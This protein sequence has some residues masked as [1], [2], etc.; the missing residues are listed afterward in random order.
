MYGVFLTKKRNKILLIGASGTLGS[1]LKKII[2]LKK[3]K[4]LQKIN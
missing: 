1:A 4:Y 3:L 2:I